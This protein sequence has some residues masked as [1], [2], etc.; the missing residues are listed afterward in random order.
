[1]SGADRA[2]WW[3]D[4]NRERYHKVLAAPF[5]LAI[6]ACGTGHEYVAGDA[7]GTTNVTAAATAT[8][9]SKG[10]P[11]VAASSATPPSRGAPAD[12]GVPYNV[13]DPRTF[14]CDK[15]LRCA[16]GKETCCYQAGMGP[17]PEAR[18]VAGPGVGP[19]ETNISRVYAK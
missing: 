12:A 4:V 17:G 8:A 2:K 16:S 3:T 14:I 1:M 18:C 9:A 19:W 5:A 6:A 13:S 7:R 10:A 15:N 11:K